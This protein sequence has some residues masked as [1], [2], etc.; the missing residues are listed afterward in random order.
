MYF[1]VFIIPSLNVVEWRVKGRQKNLWQD[2]VFFEIIF[3]VE[4]QLALD[5]NIIMT[6][7]TML[8]HQ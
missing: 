4:K 1:H 6:L 7:F 2:S 8:T 5:T 3:K